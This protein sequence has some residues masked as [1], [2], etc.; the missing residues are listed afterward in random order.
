MSGKYR[1]L[2]FLLTVSVMGMVGAATIAPWTAA[3]VTGELPLD[4]KS[5][6]WTKARA[7]VIPLVAQTVAA[8]M[9][10]GATPSV[11]VRALHNGKEVAFLL[12]WADDTVNEAVGPDT[13]RDACALM[14]ALNAKAP[15]SPFMGNKGG[16][17]IIWQWKADWQ[18]KLEGRETYPS[19]YA[20]FI[21]P[22]DSTLFGKIGNKPKWGTP[23]EELTAEGFGTLTTKKEQQVLGK[24][25]HENGK[26]RVVMIRQM[27]SAEADNITFV[28][29]GTVQVNVAVWNGA[30]K[31]VSAKKSVSM[32]W[33]PLVIQKAVVPTPAKKR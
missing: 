26:W 2:W 13:Y 3:Y 32:V 31:E 30:A 7:E 11:S 19:A 25:I 8:P 5:A 6:I 24:G 20:D 15:P 16:R 9:G 4:P 28:P 29:G 18:A 27:G 17:V 23:V 21:S 10:G 1:V 12:E 22:D 14:F 33:H